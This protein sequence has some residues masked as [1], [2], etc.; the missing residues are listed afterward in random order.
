MVDSNNAI[1]NTVGASISG[2]TNTFTIT[3]PSNTASSVARET[4]TVGGASSGDPSLNFNVSGVTD[5]EMGIDNND[6]DKLKISEGTALGT[7][8]TWIMTTAGERTMPLQPAFQAY[9]ASTDSNIT[10]DGTSFTLG[11]TDVGTALT[12][13]YNIGGHFTLGAS[14]GAFFTAPVDGIYLFNSSLNLLSISAAHTRLIAS[15]GSSGSVTRV[16]RIAE[17]SPATY[18]T[19]NNTCNFNGSAHIQ[20]VAGDKVSFTFAVFNGAKTLDLFGFA[21]SPPSITWMSGILLA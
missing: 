13:V 14:G 5:F 21:A 9:L 16:F 12:S 8:D 20:L 2:V 15:F 17:F 19:A 4:I 11:D 10:G 7:N 18:Q 6:S 3:N 1:N